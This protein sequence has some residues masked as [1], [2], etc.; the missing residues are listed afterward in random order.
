MTMENTKETQFKLSD[1]CAYLNQADQNA[2][3]G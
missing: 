3:D 2:G 1:S